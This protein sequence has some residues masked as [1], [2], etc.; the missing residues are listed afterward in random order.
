MS[1]QRGSVQHGG[2]SGQNAG[3]AI[4]DTPVGI[5][6]SVSDTVI[7][8]YMENPIKYIG[9]VRRDDI[10]F[11]IAHKG[12]KSKMTKADY[13]AA[14]TESLD[15]RIKGWLAKNEKTIVYFPYASQVGDAS[16]G[17]R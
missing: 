4:D 2:L 6:D 7:S 12:E 8:L 17:T 3:C 13:E 16:K 9:Y 15:N 11:D 10:K 14:K 5:D 1:N